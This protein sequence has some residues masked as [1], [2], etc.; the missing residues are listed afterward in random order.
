MTDATIDRQGA[1]GATRNPLLERWTL[2]LGAPPFDRVRTEDFLPAFEAAIAENR[3]EIEAIAANSEPATFENTLAALER[4][5]ETLGR[6][7]RLFWTLSSAQSDDALRAIEP[8][9][10]T[11]LT[12]HGTAISHDPRLFRR[13]AAVWRERAVLGLSEEQ[14]RLVDNGYRGFVAGG[15][16]LDGADKARF[17]EI[18]ERLG[19]LSIQF[20]HNVLA[21]AA[22]W[23][24]LLDAADLDGLPESVRGAAARRAAKRGHE[25]RFLFTLDRGDVEDVLGF[26]TR[27]DLRERIWRA[28]VGRNDGG[29]HDNRPLID[30]IVAL[31]GEKARLLGHATYADYALEDSMA[32]TPDAADGLMM[33]VW[34]PAL[35]QSRAEAATLQA[36]IDAD[37]VANG[38]EDVQLQGWDWRFYA[39]RVRREHYALDGAAVKQHLVL[40]RVRDAA[41]GAAETLY[42]LH[43]A[44]REDIPGYHPDVRAWCVT[45]AG[46]P[47]GLLYTDYFS[48]PEKHGGAWMGSLRVQETLDKE[49][50]GRVSPIV[51]T[52]ANFA[53]APVIG[54]SRLS[55]DEARTLF[56]EFGHALHALLSNVTYPSLAGT[57]VARDFVEFPSKF[58]EHWIVAP[59]VLRGF[60]VPDDLIAAIQRA[61]E[62][63]EGFATVEFLGSGIV[64]LAIHRSIDEKP[65]V[66]A[67]ERARLAEIGMP[68][69]I[70]MRHR[71]PHFTHVFDGG[72]AASY[73]AYL[74]SEVLDADA[75]A[76][77]AEA[78]DIF[79]T[80]LAARFRDEVLARG[81]SRDPMISFEAFRGRAPDEAALL[82]AR[83]LTR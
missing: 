69:E 80:V 35:A 51:Y 53:K 75:F 28:F 26:S 67:I 39:E 79:D 4:S 50:G 36:L 19:Q 71:L 6:V 13:V 59:E 55:L 82:R 7:R 20:G 5:G 21:V 8:E 25:G 23:E 3:R 68:A 61:D 66:A 24:M 64:D 41:F 78:G 72:Y 76:A 22:D 43:F 60:G 63:G 81:D 44:L 65:D 38:G 58:M 47:V 11:M 45:R 29:A 54:E 9:V 1:A 31:R 12:R 49:H 16:A 37:A 40:D 73:Y 33:R 14:Q 46:E 42:G 32:K 34:R 48:R 62:F 52:V 10:S 17:A 74:W 2:P 77:F 27:R 18:D 57:A 70:P 15:A 83:R 56:H 30:A